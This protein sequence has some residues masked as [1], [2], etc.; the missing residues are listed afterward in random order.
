M[1]NR[2]EIR[3]I[4][5]IA[6]VDHGKT[7]L[8]DAMLRQSG[9]F[10][11]N[12]Q[13]AERV[14][15][16][17]DLERERGITILSKNTAVMYDGVKMNIV[18]TPG[19]ADFS[20]EVERILGMV[21]GV[22]LL[23]DAF[24]GPMPQTKFVLGKALSLGLKPIVV[25]NKI[26]RPDADTER[27][28]DEVLDL[29]I[30]LEADEEQLEFPVVYAS[31]RQGV[32]YA[33]LQDESS[34]LKPLFETIIREVPSPQGFIDAPLQM[35]ISN[36]EYDEYLGRIVIGRIS[37]GIL[38]AG[39]GVNISKRDGKLEKAKIGKLFVYDGLKRLEVEQ[40][41]MGD[42]VCL[43]GLEEANIGE[44]VT[45]LEN[46]EALPVLQIDE[47]TLKMFFSTNNSPFA[48]REGSF[49]TSRHLRERLL[50]ELESNVS[51]RVTETESPDIY[52]VAG[53]GELHLSILIETMRR[54]GYE[55]QVSKPEVILKKS[56]NGGWLEPIENL[57]I[58]VPEEYMGVIM[59]MVSIRKGE[60]T[61]MHNTGTGQMRMEF[62]IP[63]RG[64]I[65][66]RS[67]FLTETKGYGIMNHTFRGYNEYRGD[68]THR[69][70]GVLIASE[71]AET[72]AYGLYHSQD[73]GILF[74]GAG[75]AIYE[76]MIVGENPRN[77]DI[78]VNVC[79]KKHITNMRAS[80]SDE[81]LRLTPPHIMSL[82]ESLEYIN[83]DEL[84]EVT[85]KTIRLRKKILNTTERM[86]AVRRKNS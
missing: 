1:Q 63:A 85:P 34:S 53:R 69:S 17:N 38:K 75:Q 13:V 42:I 47:P 16:S 71:T 24:E 29:F 30:E 70:T 60:M 35:L 48:G 21:D 2:N 11:S 82:E 36:L 3:N 79:K 22:L 57:I 4:A 76:G 80:G 37:R 86:R 72:T 33:V 68:I 74:V 54:E 59:E 52:E 27:V 67:S 58:D 83:D 55:F 8:V 7:T 19:H 51:L 73:R 15:D 61:N 9:I 45:C 62:E 39:Q 46:P 14:M 6:H 50:K 49:V 5:I 41:T 43:T 26:D 44:T 20:G 77:L 31:A 40:A 23:V 25:I 56:E 84:V 28:L 65:G 18:D 10:R 32:A 66:F 64:L 12:E 81:T 78:E